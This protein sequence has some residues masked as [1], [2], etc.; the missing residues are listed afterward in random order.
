MTRPKYESPADLAAERHVARLIE[1][2]W[3]AQLQ[4]LPDQYKLDFAAYR[5]GELVA[6]L[7]IKNRTHAAGA[8]PTLIL[9]VAKWHAGVALA[10]TSG[11]PFL[12]VA[13]FVDG[14]KFVRYSRGKVLDV[15]YGPGG[16]T[17]RGDAQDQEP[18]IHIPME[19]F[20]PIRR[21][22]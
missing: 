8:Y 3:K 16:R 10:V 5:D 4:K 14:A 7:E 19:L 15:R 9:S 17:D 1:R 18:V 11:C 22:A 13:N 12:V 21:T 2:E 6:W 20:K